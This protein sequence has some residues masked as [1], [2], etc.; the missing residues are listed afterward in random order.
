MTWRAGILLTIAAPCLLTG[1]GTG[2]RSVQGVP[3]SLLVDA[4]V[5]VYTASA[6]ARLEGTDPAVARAEVLAGIGLDTMRFNRTLDDLAAS[7]DSAAAVYQRAL[8]SLVVSE[9]NL[10]SGAT[11]DSLE[12]QIR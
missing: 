1:C 8:D 3:D 9:R 2:D 5:G 7:P 11:R 10:K 12:M 4:I 6:R